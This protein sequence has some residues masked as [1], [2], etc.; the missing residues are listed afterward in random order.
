MITVVTPCFNSVA[1][2]A[3]TLE[4]VRTQGYPNLEHIVIDAGS[5]DGGLE[6]LKSTPGIRYISEPDRGL[7]DGLN[8]GIQMAHGEVIGCLN[9]DDHYLP[10][11]LGAVGRA[12]AQHPD[13]LWMTG[14]CTIIDAQGNEIRKAVTA[15]KNLFLRRY[16]FALHLTQNFV[17]APST[18]V[19]KA[20]YDRVGEYDIEL[21]YAMDYD[22]FLRCAK[23]ADPLV[24]DRPLATFRMAEGS[25]SISGFKKQFVEHEMI[26]RAHGGRHPAAVRINAGT[27]R[28]IVAIYGL[29]ARLRRAR[30]RRSTTLRSD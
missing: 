27:S 16:S 7:S 13:A 12:Y 5:T 11:A 30:G 14:P 8:K 21:H 1:T 2:L 26:A 20:A 10:G 15:Y 25:M 18:F 4:S 3:E 6:I 24:L 17:S 22:V 28:L 23:L 9:A 29:L 19:T